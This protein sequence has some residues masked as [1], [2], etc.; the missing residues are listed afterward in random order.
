MNRHHHDHLVPALNHE[1]NPGKLL[2]VASSF[3]GASG[4]IIAVD[5]NPSP[6]AYDRIGCVNITCV[7]V[8]SEFGFYRERPGK[9]RRLPGR[10]S[11]LP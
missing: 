9:R 2:T 10:C 1:P 11:C 3:Q 6:V 8:V 5:L 4:R 7:E